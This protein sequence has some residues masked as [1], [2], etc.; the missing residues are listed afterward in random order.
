MAWPWRLSARGRA[1]VDAQGRCDGMAPKKS[2]HPPAFC[3]G[4]GRG[5]PLRQGQKQ[6]S[7]IS[8]VNSR[9]EALGY[10]TRRSPGCFCRALQMGFS[11]GITRI[12]LPEQV[13]YPPPVIRPVANLR[14]WMGTSVRRSREKNVTHYKKLVRIGQI[15]TTTM[16]KLKMLVRF[17]VLHRDRSIALF[18]EGLGHRRFH[19]RTVILVNEHTKSAAEMVAEFAAMNGLATLVGTRTAGEVLGAANFLVGEGYRLRIPIGGWMTWDDRLLEGIGTSPK[20]AIEPIVAALRAGRDT[21][22]EKATS[23]L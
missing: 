23:I 22:L 17:K 8:L 13:S 4:R 18:T 12:C 7:H 2:A 9:A 6:N 19:G 1:R 14:T 15:P 11:A 21:A 5:A 16:A 10:K 20:F 3:Y